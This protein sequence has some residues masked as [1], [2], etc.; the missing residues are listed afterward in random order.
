[1]LTAINPLT[2]A[3][4]HPVPPF[5]TFAGGRFSFIYCYVRRGF[6]SAPKKETMNKITIDG[7]EY[8]VIFNMST[9][10]AFEQTAGHSF[11]ADQFNTMYSRILLVFA[12]MFAA[13]ESIEVSILTK[14]KDFRGIMSAYA[15]VEK[16]ALEF[17]KVPE[18]VKDSEQ[19]ESQDNKDKTDTKN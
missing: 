15:E 5:L 14:S 17:F 4:L 7:K 18:V 11:F 13:D 6:A 9:L 19:Q 12:A 3:R 8:P 2:A 16:M 1:M 10:I